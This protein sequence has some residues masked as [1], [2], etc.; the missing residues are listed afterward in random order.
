MNNSLSLHIALITFTVSDLI[1]SMICMF[2]YSGFDRFWP[3]CCSSFTSSWLYSCS[4]YMT[5]CLKLELI[6]VLHG[7]AFEF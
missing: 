3:N 2:V 4:V 6:S 7:K 5:V 1:R